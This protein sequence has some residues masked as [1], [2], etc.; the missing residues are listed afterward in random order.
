M[1]N[2]LKSR[3]NKDLFDKIYK[4]TDKICKGM[5]ITFS[6]RCY[7]I[8]H[9]M[10]DFPECSNENCH[11]KIIENI[12]SFKTGFHRFCSVKCASESEIT[13]EKIGKTKTEKYGCSYFNNYE[14][15]RKTNLE[16]YGVEHTFQTENNQK[17]SRITKLEKY[18]DENFINVEKMKET[19]LGRYGNHC[20]LANPE[21]HE[22]RSQ[23][24]IERYGVEYSLQSDE[25]RDRMKNTCLELYGDENYHNPEQSRQT[26][27]EKYGD[28]FFNNREK[29]H[30]TCLAR[31][32]VDSYC[33]TEEYK[34]KIYETCMER[35]GVPTYL[36]AEGFKKRSEE[37]CL[38]RFGVSYYSQTE[39]SREHTA[40]WH[41][42]EFFDHLLKCPNVMPLFDRHE[43]KRR[44]RDKPLKWKCNRCGTEFFSKIDHKY[45][46]AHGFASYARCPECDRHSSAKSDGELELLEC[47]RGIYH[48]RIE[49]G[50]RKTI[51][52]KEIDIMLRGIST[53]IE[54]DG[55]IWHSEYFGKGPEQMLEKTLLCESKGVRLIRVYSD[56]WY[57]DKKN[58]LW[59]LGILISDVRHDVK[60][61]AIASEDERRS[62][63]CGEHKIGSYSVHEDSV[64]DIVL[65]TS[66][67]NKEC[68]EHIVEFE[69]SCGN[70]ITSF[71][72][73]RRFYSVNQVAGMSDRFEFLNPTRYVIRSSNERLELDVECDKVLSYIWDCGYIKMII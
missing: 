59:K 64:V 23:T 33:S 57:S 54:Y 1:F 2:L 18:G 21:I 66:D 8:F 42:V 68:L 40:E 45:A 52:P 31:Y 5:D 29:Y 58:T 49:S 30:K 53:G 39:K 22:K 37:A 10:K 7:L 32:G 43:L 36:Q 44:E 15:T 34:R 50:D 65:G 72:F 26:K 70:E 13:K 51:K 41:S 25:I 38:E 3:K 4:L 12:N 14:K 56:E 55:L 28:E 46:Q 73:D 71:I 62:M 16:R 35:Y 11:N 48:G 67:L 9:G 47:L 69:K 60:D 27:L 24:M 20:P 61:L 19:N 6:T 17:K 63:M